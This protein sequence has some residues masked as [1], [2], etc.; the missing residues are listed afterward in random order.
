MLPD[1]QKPRNKYQI[2]SFTDSHKSSVLDSKPSKQESSVSHSG[3]S[4]KPKKIVDVNFI[5]MSQEKLGSSGIIQKTKK[6]E[7]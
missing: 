4:Y 5:G 1:I 6:I 7:M 3:N 2:K